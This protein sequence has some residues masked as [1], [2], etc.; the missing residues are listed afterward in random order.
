MVK[1]T[2]AVTLN[3][4]T[5]FTGSVAIQIMHM[6]VML[7]TTAFWLKFDFHTKCVCAA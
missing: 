5:K 2:S 6:V 7:G 3:F 4:I 1:M